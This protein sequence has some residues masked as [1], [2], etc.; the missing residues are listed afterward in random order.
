MAAAWL[1]V[2]FWFTSRSDAEVP[3]EVVSALE[4]EEARKTEE[5]ET[6]LPAEKAD[7]ESNA[8]LESGLMI[9]TDEQCEAIYEGTATA[10]EIKAELGI[11]AALEQT[12]A[13]SAAAESGPAATET[14][15]GTTGA[16][17]P[18]SE[19][20][21]TEPTAAELLLTDCTAELSALQ[22]DLMAQL[23]VMKQEVLDEWYA[24]SAE[25]QTDAKKKELAFAG[26]DQCYALE[27][28]VD[29][30]VQ[31]VLD[32]Y[33][34]ELQALGADTSSIDALWDYYVAEKTRQ[35]N[36]YLSYLN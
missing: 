22:I 14:E 11:T 18:G 21:A 31:A 33:E 32:R 24:L 26:L 1:G 20:A 19:T 7:G 35:E 29:E 3:E 9:A 17:A 34:A 12:G 4:A 23:A 16:A 25:E 6:L 27:A 5:K 28:V 13:Q 30:E 8:A 15:T 10:E 36:Y 2:L